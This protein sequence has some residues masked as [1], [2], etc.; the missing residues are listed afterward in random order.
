MNA[1]PSFAWT[2]RLTLVGAGILGCA[3]AIMP[4]NA[5]N[6]AQSPLSIKAAPPPLIMLTLGRDHKLY[7]E[8]YDDYSDLDGDGKIDTG[9]IANSQFKYAG[10]F[11][12]EKCYDYANG[13]FTPV[14]MATDKKCQGTGAGQWSGDFLNYVT[15]S[16][17]DAIRKVLYGGKRSTDTAGKTILER[18]HIPQDAHTWGKEYNPNRDSY[19]ITDY[20]PLDKPKLGTRHLFANVSLITDN[21]T[22]LMR[23]LPDSQYRIWDWVTIQA[24]VAGDRCLGGKNPG[25]GQNKG[26]LC[27]SRDKQSWAIVPSSRTHGLSDLKMTTY[28]VAPWEDVVPTYFA[29]IVTGNNSVNKIP[30]SNAEFDVEENETIKWGSLCGKVSAPNI[31]GKG[32]PMAW[33]VGGPGLGSKFNDT[34]VYKEPEY[35]NI[36]SHCTQENFF[37]IFE[38]K[39]N[40]EE[41]G[42]YRFGLE[43][44]DAAELIIGGK[45]VAVIAGEV[46][47]LFSCWLEGGREEKT[48]LQHFQKDSEPASGT[49]TL[50]KG[51]HTIKYRYRNGLGD[52]AYRLYWKLENLSQTAIKDY[53]VRVEVCKAVDANAEY[54]GRE[55]NCRDYGTEPAVVYKPTGLLHQYGQANGMLFGLITGSYDQNLDG[56]VLRKAFGSI[57]DEIET[58][59]GIFKD[60]GTTC[61]DA[62]NAPCTKGIIGSID[63]L[64][65]RMEAFKANYDLLNYDNAD[66]GSK[67]CDFLTKPENLQN[68]QCEMWGNPLAEMMYEGLRY[69]A[70][71]TQ[72]TPA[73][74]TSRK[75]DDAIGLPRAAWSNPYAQFPRCSQPYFMLM[76][77]VYPSFDAD[78]LPGS[79]FGSTPAQSINGYPL[80]FETLGGALWNTEFKGTRSVF[81][82]QVKGVVTDS[83]D[84]AP[85]VKPGVMDFS[86]I[87]GLVPSDPS[88]QGSYYSSLLAYFAHSYDINS[89]KDRQSVTTYAIALSAPI[90]RIVI[91]VGTNKKMTFVPFAKS[92]GYNSGNYTTIGTGPGQWTPSAQIVDFYVETIRNANGTDD[93]ATNGGRP[94][95]KFRVNFEDAEQGGDYDMDV[96][97]VYEIWVDEKGDVLVAVSSEQAE[98]G[99]IQHIGYVVSGTKDKDGARLVVRDRDTSREED[100]VISYPLD[101]RGLSTKGLPIYDVQRFELKEKSWVQQLTDDVLLENPLWYAAK[102]GAFKDSNGNKLPDLPSEWDADGDGVPDTYFPVTSPHRLYSQIDKALASIAR[103][104]AGSVAQAAAS[105]TSLQT[106]AH[107]FIAGLNS[108]GWKGELNAYKVTESGLSGP[109]WRAH[110]K[111]ADLSGENRTILTFDPQKSSGTGIPFRWSAMTAGGVLQSTLNKQANGTTDSLGERRLK[112]LRGLNVTNMRITAD[113]KLGDIVNS[114]PMYVGPPKLGHQDAS[115]KSFAEDKAGRTPMVYV[116]ANDGMLHGFRA[117]TGEEKLA[118]VPS[119]LYRAR[120]GEQ[121]LSKLTQPGYGSSG[122]Q[123]QYYV[124]RLAGHGRHLHGELH[125]EDG[126]ENHPRRR[127]QCRRSGRLRARHH[128]SRRLRREQARHRE[129]GIPRRR[130]QR[131]HQFAERRRGSR[132]HL[133]P[134]RHRPAM[135]GGTRLGLRPLYAE[136]VVRRLRQRLRQHRGRRPRRHRTCG[137]VR[138]GRRHRPASRQDHVARRRRRGRPERSVRSDAERH[139]RRRGG[140]LRLRRRPERQRVAHRF[141]H[142]GR[143]ARPERRDRPA[144]Y[145]QERRRQCPT[146][147]HGARSR[148]PSA[149]RH[150]GHLRHR[151]VH[152]RRR[153]ILDPDADALRYLGQTGRQYPR[154]HQRPRQAAGADGGERGHRGRPDVLRVVQ[155][156]GRL[157]DAD[158]LVHRS[159]P[160]RA[161]HL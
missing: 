97:A 152:L 143:A 38:G 133:R 85:T 37:A 26:P 20:T 102:F 86:V 87:R 94:Y 33:P 48:L 117:D 52:Q 149:W 156:N 17:L 50:A 71:E 112:N 83:A 46:C 130:F 62:G 157:V 61:G 47:G 145:G 135:H 118:Y 4:A 18:A 76:S 73:F 125:G 34:T 109:T 128:R 150:A 70:G 19:D 120:R 77:D 88:R 141:R 72:P 99:I 3:S 132:L 57:T 27:T 11:D 78:R 131:Q 53:A 114:A 56:G 35:W 30:T 111:L 81:I 75:K 148:R 59:T 113:N 122:N 96:M 91:P 68:G 159:G 147:H 58:A 69:F 41:A 116:G 21:G 161:H 144:L 98:G 115:Y 23:V 142:Q 146:D 138:T 153:S 101:K 24:P 13:V 151:P 100:D 110:E 67:S 64:R 134:A 7:H 74:V 15:T 66:N 80:D 155:Q 140:G 137:P 129:V 90:P 84:K 22:P 55:S 5:L 106:D 63:R 25:N 79:A 92:V 60:S 105:S 123:H 14:R 31:D 6:L 108:D 32:N 124:E 39:I 82:G 40:V 43:A 107:V 127:T 2:K 65:T 10:Y 29:G 126:L 139:R 93:P 45:S 160:E 42:T 12:S 28:R 95:Y 9:Y 119:E 54:Q 103:N 1:R 104:A 49:I 44:D 154:R 8:A 89:A 36:P 51:Q 136:Q 121:P 158:R 16:R